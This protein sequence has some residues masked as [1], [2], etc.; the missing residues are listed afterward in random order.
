MIV[1]NSSYNLQAQK[2]KITVN[3]TI[4]MPTEVSQNERLNAFSI[5]FLQSL[6]TDGQ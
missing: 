2:T 6:M 5:F 3:K 1:L 4:S